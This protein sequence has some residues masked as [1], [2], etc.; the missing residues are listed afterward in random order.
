MPWHL[1]ADLQ[2]FK[3]LTLGHPIV[4]GR[5]TF[6]SIG[7]ALPE[8]QNIVI[9]RSLREAPSGCV[10]A[11]SLDD[12]LARAE[13]QPVMIV[14]G[15]TLYAQALPLARRM[16]LTLV[17]AAPEGDTLFPEIDRDWSLRR[18]RVRPAD[19][20]N[21]YRLVFCSLEKST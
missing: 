3:S 2:H 8:R 13:G 17:D 21:P 15:G 6:D 7:R 19:D 16:E 9:S 14:G 18:M 5:R 20:R 4:M 10:L 12:A 1:P 11:A